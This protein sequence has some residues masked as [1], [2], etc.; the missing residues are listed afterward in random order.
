MTR[1]VDGFVRLDEHGIA[2]MDIVQGRA[3]QEIQ[4]VEAL[5]RQIVGPRAEIT[6]LRKKK[7]VGKL[8]NY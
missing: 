3:V 8:L 4:P 1:L 5:R 2:L 6:D 7:I